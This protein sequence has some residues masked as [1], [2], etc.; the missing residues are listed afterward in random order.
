[1]RLKGLNPT[2]DLDVFFPGGSGSPAF[3]TYLEDLEK[4]VARFQAEVTGP[5]TASGVARWVQRLNLLQDLALRLRQAAA[6]VSCLNAQDVKDHQARLLGGRVKQI[7]ARYASALSFMDQALLQI[8]ADQWQ[9]ILSSPELQPLAFNL[10]ER[11]RRAQEKMA[12]E[13]ESL[14]NDLAVDGY[15][16]WSELYDAV[17]GRMTIPVP[18]DG[19]VVLVSPAQASNRMISPD[20]KV[21]QQVMLNWE[22]AWSDVADL[23]ASALNHLAGFRLNL[24]HHRGWES[25]LKEPLEI[26]RMSAATLEAMWQAVNAN[27]DR[28]VTYLKRK[29]KALGLTALGWQDVNAPLGQADRKFSYDEAANFIVEQ[30]GRFD[31]DLAQFAANAFSQRWIEAED[32]PGKR[33]GGFC[34]SFPTSRQS[35]IFLTFSGNLGNLGTLAHELGHAYHQHVMADLPALAQ[36]YA[37]NVAETASTFAELIVSNAAI[38]QAQDPQERL[39]LIDDKLS[40]ATGLLMN[41]QARFLFETRFYEARK[42]GP[43]SVTALNELMVEAQKEAYREALDLY[44]PHFW[45]SKLHFYIT[46]TP[47]YNFPYTFGF[48]FSNGVYARAREEGPAFAKKYVELLRD[49][50]RMRVEDLAW[51]HLAADLTRSDFWEQAILTALADLDEFLR[52]TE[53]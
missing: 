52:L 45:A 15:H 2:W 9:E 12:P 46:N 34:T 35:R 8:P 42:K 48:L 11:R 30:F 28:L 20:P 18:E 26:N 36:Q 41:I 22:Q 13:L 49:T 23:C 1:M 47:F 40:G 14:A 24:Y 6:F 17:V 27:K 19:K 31:L 50:G 44:H 38:A 3:A 4:D 37:M 7:Q 21:R 32:R 29:Q 10:E 16:G 39:F 43:L 51:K 33:P 53:S 5:T 25:P